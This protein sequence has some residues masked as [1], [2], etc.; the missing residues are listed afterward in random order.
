M[1][2]RRFCA[3]CA[4]AQAILAA[5]PDLEAAIRFAQCRRVHRLHRCMREIRDL[6]QA[7]DRRLI[8]QRLGSLPQ[9]ELMFDGRLIQR[10]KLLLADAV[11]GNRCIACVA[12][13][14]LQRLR[15]PAARCAPQKRCAATMTA[16]SSLMAFSMPGLPA[17]LGSF[18]EISLPPT[19][20]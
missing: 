13:Y 16:S 6:V 11:G 12:E 1:Q 19:I 18:T 7:L 3:E 17:M 4:R 5:R 14:R 10:L 2:A 20:G 15:R 8:L 9:G